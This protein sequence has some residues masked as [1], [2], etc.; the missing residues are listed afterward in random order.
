MDYTQFM[1]LLKEDDISSRDSVT[2]LQ[3]FVKEFPYFQSAH[4]LLAKS[5][6]DQQHVRFEKQLKIASAYVGDR[7]SLY[8]QIHSVERFPVREILSVE[9]SPFVTPE[10]KEETVEQKIIDPVEDI[11]A[12]DFKV[13]NSKDVESKADDLKD[14]DLIS[15]DFKVE[16]FNKT[17]S[18]PDETETI[19]SIPSINK[20]VHLPP[21][22]FYGKEPNEEPFSEFD[23]PPVADPHD[24]IRRRLVE[25]LGLKE[26]FSPKEISKPV[27]NVKDELLNQPEPEVKTRESS[28]VINELPVEEEVELKKTVGENSNINS[29]AMEQLVEESTKAVDFIQK[30]ELEYALESTLI[31]SLE[32]LPIIPKAIPT[33]S[34]KKANT[35]I[36]WLKINK[37]EG[38]GKVEEVH[39]YEA[40]VSSEKVHGIGER[41]TIV[42]TESES[43]TETE[44]KGKP[45]E[46]ITLLIDKFIESDPKIVPSKIDFYSPA[47]Q[48][49]K[50]ITENEDLV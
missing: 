18:N 35:F 27:S 39:A 8:D 7:K 33:T 17:E 6:H 49:K 15:H 5:M 41:E 30:A 26:D 48:A 3:E 32:K 47:S 37:V 46:D 14:Y 12:N 25:I 2:S 34:A 23:D 28:E 11:K 42:E 36:D 45:G 22:S 31:Q 20:V 40:E 13:E 24:I 43:E 9:N 19:L 21:L 10:I 38:Y 4:A 50:S 1:K 16:D 44:N 29:D